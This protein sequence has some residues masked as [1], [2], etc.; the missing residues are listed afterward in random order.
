VQE[1][2]S[3]PNPLCGVCKSRN[4]TLLVNF[5]KATIN[6]II[7]KALVLPIEEGGAG[8][9]LEDIVILEGNR[10]KIRNSLFILL[11]MELILSANRMLYDIDEEEN[12]KLL[13][14][15]LSLTEGK[16]LRIEG[17]EQDIDLLLEAM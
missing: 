13:L 5:E 6:D 14:K 16:I 7:D 1:A 12:A 11:K 4:S 9:D 10:Y 15:E 2:N 8:I 17:S 3:E